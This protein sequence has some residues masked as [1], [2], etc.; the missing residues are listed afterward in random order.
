[1]IDRDDPYPLTI[2][3]FDDVEGLTRRGDCSVAEPGIRGEIHFINTL[4]DLAA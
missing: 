3:R 1:M 2:R 4:F